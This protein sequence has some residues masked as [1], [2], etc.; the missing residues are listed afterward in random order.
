LQLRAIVIA[1]AGQ[2]FARAE[3]QGREFSRVN[4]CRALAYVLVGERQTNIDAMTDRLAA[5]RIFC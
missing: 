1:V 5:W 4:A 2:E 3:Q